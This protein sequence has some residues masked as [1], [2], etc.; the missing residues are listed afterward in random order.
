[1][2]ITIEL[3]CLHCQRPNIIRNGKNLYGPQNYLCKD[4]GI[5]FITDHDKTYKGCLS[6]TTDIIKIMLLRGIGIRDLCVILK[7]SARKVLKTLNLTNYEIIPRK[8]HY[9]TIEI[10]EL[11]T[12]V[13]SKNNKLWLIYA[14]CRKTGEI[15]AYVW[16]KRDLK[17][18]IEL[19][20]RLEELGISYNLIASDSWDSFLKAFDENEKIT[21]KR[22]TVGIEGNNCRRAYK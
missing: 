1:M 12:Y 10:D 4:C 16:G 9:D 7:V 5:L 17:T 2:K 8:K 21:G 6:W 14:Y 22:Y 3:N 20:K 11:W 13:G 18:A 19:K 15:I